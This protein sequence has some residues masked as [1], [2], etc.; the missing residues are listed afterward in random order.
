M[1]TPLH[2]LAKV[3]RGGS[4]EDALA[5]CLRGKPFNDVA[6][7]AS[8]R[9]EGSGD[10]RAVF[11]NSRILVSASRYFRE[12][13]SEKRDSE[14]L[15]RPL[16][17]ASAM[18]VDGARDEGSTL[19]DEDDL[20]ALESLLATPS[21]VWFRDDEDINLPDGASEDTQSTPAAVSTE[22]ST[23]LV[24]LDN[25]SAD[26]LEAVI[27]YIYTGNVHF[28][29][30]NAPVPNDA[31]VNRA[32]NRPNRPACSCKAAYRFAEEAG[33]DELQHL[34][35]A[36][37]FAQLDADTI[38]AKVFSQFSSQHPTILRKQVDLLLAHF[39]TPATRTALG[40][41]IARVVRGELPHAAP[42]LAM[43]LE[44]IPP[45][46]AL[47]GSAS[48]GEGYS[49]L[50][51]PPTGPARPP[52]DTTPG[53]PA[54]MSAPSS[55]ATAPSSSTLPA[56][57]P[58]PAPITPPTEDPGALTEGAGTRAAQDGAPAHVPAVRA[59]SAPVVPTAP[60]AGPAP[61]SSPVRCPV[62]TDG[63]CVSRA[64]GAARGAVGLSARANA[65][66]TH[67][68][69]GREPL[70]M[71]SKERLSGNEIG[72]RKDGKKGKK[73]GSKGKADWAGWQG[74][75]CGLDSCLT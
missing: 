33:L 46:P 47:C 72:K 71:P 38:L 73:R 37:L 21:E 55:T 53:D 67:S 42:V 64:A 30:L 23:R 4:L 50:N 7:Y 20:D 13:F 41:V 34:A 35:E 74:N 15:S 62:E 60:T 29:P 2:T 39:W 59:A 43:L 48:A 18:T 51:L 75:S 44:E 68:V 11:A 52:V 5:D 63:S 19:G 22:S 31:Q 16:P 56:T 9:D 57:R 58:G 1:F 25:V 40:P 3:P 14:P 12:L 49:R 70:G 27:F 61:P 66:G 17:E 65:V 10:P 54:A 24:T 32:K 36:H 69:L 28:L 8:A 45:R 6:F 26:T